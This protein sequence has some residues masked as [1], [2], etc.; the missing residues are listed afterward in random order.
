MSRLAGF[1]G[2]LDG[3][4]VF[5]VTWKN[6]LE[7]D[8]FI[9][10]FCFKNNLVKDKSK[11][12]D[13]TELE[14]INYDAFEKLCLELDHK[15]KNGL[16]EEDMLMHNLEDAQYQWH[17]IMD[18]IF[19]FLDW[20]ADSY[21]NKITFEFFSCVQSLT[22]AEKFAI[23]MYQKKGTQLFHLIRIGNLRPYELGVG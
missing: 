21:I 19:E 13:N 7:M 22:N 4:E 16:K 3:E 17:C 18:K 1:I 11:S 23:I 8:S 6:Y 2:T 12:D 14:F 10:Q 15:V 9:C 20:H 5:A